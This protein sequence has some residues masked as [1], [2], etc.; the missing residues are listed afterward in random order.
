MSSD[1]GQS[2][3]RPAESEARLE[4]QI[5]RAKRGSTSALGRALNACRPRLLRAA[6]RA[7][8]HRLRPVVGASDIVQETFVNATRAF[9][10]FRGSRASEF[11]NWLHRILANK[12]AEVARREK[13][14]SD[15]ARVPLEALTEP[16]RNRS[17]EGSDSPSSIVGN[18]E[19]SDMI[20][21]GLA[22]LPERYQQVL[23]LRFSDGLNFPQIGERMNLTEDGARMLFSR[24]VK[25]L[26]KKMPPKPEK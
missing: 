24:A 18:Q 25:R 26:R 19:F 17:N 6:R 11:V 1:G 14:T 12:L 3:G 9:R 20:V 13:S 15:A 22:R 7:V 4:E 16:W 21:A 23:D 2:S 5:D 10:V 8:A